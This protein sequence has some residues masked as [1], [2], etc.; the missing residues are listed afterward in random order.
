[1]IRSDVTAKRQPLAGR[2]LYLEVNMLAEFHLRVR[3]YKT[4]TETDIVNPGLMPA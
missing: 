4:A 1:M 3:I 2:K